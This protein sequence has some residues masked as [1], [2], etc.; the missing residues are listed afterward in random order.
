[1]TDLLLIFLLVGAATGSLARIITTERGPGAVLYRFRSWMRGRKSK[2]G[3]EVAMALSCSICAGF[4][5]AMILS[6]YAA[7]SVYVL[8]APLLLLPIL[9]FSAMGLGYAALGMGNLWSQ[10]HEK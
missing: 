4:W 1:M 6:L 2:V 9:P 7:I 3:Q 10:P 5:I 8:C